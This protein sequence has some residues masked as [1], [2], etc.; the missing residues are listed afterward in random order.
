[1]ASK[2]AKAKC[3]K[4]KGSSA[5][6]SHP[7]SSAGV[8]GPSV[9]R[10][11]AP[12]FV[13]TA[14]EQNSRADVCV[15]GA[16]IAGL[17][18]AYLLAREGKSVVVVEKDK[19]GGSET[20]HASSYF[21][22]LMDAGYRKIESI[23]GEKS[24]RLAA[25]SRSSAITRIDFIVAREQ[26]HCDFERVNGYLF[27]GPK[28]SRKDL[29]EEFEAAERAGVKLRELERPPFDLKLGPCL[30]FRRQAQ[31]HP[32]KYM[33]GLVAAIKRYGGRIYSRT[34]AIEIRGGKTVE[35]RTRN[36][37]KISAGAVVVTTNAP[38]NDRMPMHTKQSVYKSYVIGIPIPTGSIP[39]ALYLDTENPFH[40]VRV[41]RMKDG[42]A[43]RDVLIVGG[44]AHKMGHSEDPEI[45]F[46]RLRAWARAHFVAAGEL[47]F[48]W[49][50]QITKS[51]DG[52]GLIGRNPGDDE[53]VYIAAGDSGMGLTHGTI[54]G[55]LLTDLILERD[56]TWTTLYDPSRKSL[57]AASE[58]ATDNL[59]VAA[60]YP[61]RVTPSEVSTAEEIKPGTAAVIRKGFS[62]IHVYRDAS[63]KL[64]SAVCP[65]SGCVLAWNPSDRSWYCPC[66]GSLCQSES[67]RSLDK[68]GLQ[69][70]AMPTLFLI[71]GLPGA[72]KTTLAKRLE[73]ERAALRLTS[74]EWI[75]PLFDGDIERSKLEAR[76]SLVEALQW[77]VAARVLASGVDV[78][79]DWGFCLR[80]EREE[81]RSRAEALVAR[82]EL[83]FLDVPRSDLR[84]R[85]ANRSANL[86][87]EA[88]YMDGA[89][90]D[91]WSN[92]FERPT[93][94][95]LGSFQN[96]L[97]TRS[98]SE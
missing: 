46:A 36:E 17:T 12:P 42:R 48:Q 20:S 4:R 85:L 6:P 72:G 53:N 7:R 10:A 87:P 90:L 50:G 2:T 88:Y 65:H 40:F 5:K 15:V 16:G 49:S 86:P 18:T 14:L 43:E 23:H 81:Y 21:P 73:H 39:K 28:D 37:R 31:F 98:T 11:T 91:L 1:M 93:S 62:R 84:T 35:I 19:V 22:N 64:S 57:H 55:M 79:L 76:R 34:E 33:A 60:E 45:R 92:R 25:Q 89:Q 59:D 70:D 13:L 63:G 94:V 9:W 24:A 41:V 61:S 97:E 96:S 69:G 66:H 80:R 58:T 68:L 30:Q 82:A 77:E 67:S 26:I 47:E 83:R 74:D 51:V 29:H 27:L 75:A 38:F 3:R 78:I 71:C 95:E 54:A 8:R 56:N 32:L 44:E 52:F